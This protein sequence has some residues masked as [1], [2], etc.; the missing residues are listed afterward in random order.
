[1]K[2]KI[3]HDLSFAKD[4]TV[5][6]CQSWFSIR[7]PGFSE[8]N[9]IKTK[10][11]NH[12]LMLPEDISKIFDPKGKKVASVLSVDN[13]KKKKLDCYFVSS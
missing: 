3:T 9:S 12:R 1:M 7:E 4:S 8:K 13:N 2:I 6:V 5:K 10:H 11:L